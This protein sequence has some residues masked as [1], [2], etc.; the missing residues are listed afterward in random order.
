MLPYGRI[1]QV[2]KTLASGREFWSNLKYYFAAPSP[3]SAPPKPKLGLGRHPEQVP[4]GGRNDV[5]RRTV[6]AVSSVLVVSGLLLLAD[7][8]ITVI[9]QEP[10]SALRAKS[11]QGALTD[12]LAADRALHRLRL[13]VLRRPMNERRRMAFL[14]EAMRRAAKPGDPIGRIRVSRMKISFVVVQDTGSASL[15]EGPA[16]YRDTVWPG[17]RGTVGIAGHRTTYLAPFRKLNTVRPGDPI[18]VEM[19][20]GR[21]VYRAEQ[22]KIVSPHAYNYVMRPVGYDRL[23]LTA[24]H[25]LYSDNQRMVVFARLVSMQARGPARTANER[26]DGGPNEGT[27]G[28]LSPKA[29]RMRHAPGQ[30]KLPRF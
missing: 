17:L 15:R 23:A 19:P 3:V 10:I 8:T 21:F 28:N 14:A 13:Q 6:R 27:R 11:S 25:P 5:M 29:P 26:F 18:V 2:L 24:C 9:W 1:Y 16:H 4:G 30:P 7:A 12:Q 20:Y 22:R